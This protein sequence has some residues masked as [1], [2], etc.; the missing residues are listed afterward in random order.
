VRISEF[1]WI[2]R[3]LKTVWVHD[4]YCVSKF[5]SISVT[6]A[7]LCF[8]LYKIL[9][10]LVVFLARYHWQNCSL[11]RQPFESLHLYITTNPKLHLAYIPVACL[12]T[13][14]SETLYKLHVQKNRSQ[15]CVIFAYLKYVPLS[16][17]LLSNNRSFA[18]LLLWK[19]FLI[20]LFF[21]G[22]TFQTCTVTRC[23]AWQSI[24][25]YTSIFLTLFYIYE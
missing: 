21:K 1:P 16:H 17:S 15:T 7:E 10:A 4:P 20:K 8:G 5:I 2:L 14:L 6:L 23:R 22:Y 24:T 18:N 11:T 12:L 3:G 13:Y 25:V 9:N 19:A